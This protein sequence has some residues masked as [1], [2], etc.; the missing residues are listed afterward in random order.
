MKL[1]NL[2]V[3]AACFSGISANA[4]I[5]PGF[6]PGNLI[7]LRVG[8]GT[9]APASSGDPVFLDEFTPLGV[10]TNTVAVPTNGPA[11]LIIGS[12][13]S[14]GAISL[15]ANSNYVVMVGYNTNFPYTSS[16]ASS[17]SAAVPRGIATIDFNG[18][19]NFITNTKTAFSGNNIRS[20]VSDGSNNFWAAGAVS[21]TV[22]MGAAAPFA[23]VQTSDANSEVV[24]IFNGNLCF[25]SQ[26]TTPIG[27]Y[28]FTGAPVT[29]N[30]SAA[31]LFSTGAGSS[32]YG[33]AIS[34]DNTVAY[35]AADRA[36]TSG[37][38]ILKYTN[39]GAWGLAYT[40][41]TGAGSTAGARG[42]T[43][44]FGQPNVIY[45][46]TA[47]ATANRLITITDTDASAA[48]TVL[49][50]AGANEVFRG[51]QFTPQGSAPSV[52]TPLQS[53]TANQGQSATFTV[54]A[55][56]S[57][58]LYYL[59][60]SNSVPLTGWE[61]ND[62]IT[63]DTTTNEATGSFP[64][65][66]LISNSWGTSSS[67]TTLTINPSNVPPA[68]PI[69]LEPP[70]SEEVNASSNASFAVVAT[71]P[72]LTYQ[73][74]WNNT[75]LTN[76]DF[77]SGATTPDLTLSNVFGAS[78]GSY[79]VII[80]N[81]GG[82]KISAPATLAV[83]DPWISSQPAGRTFLAG[84]T[85]ELPAIAI[86]TAVNYQ[87]TF[88]GANIPGAT[89][90]IFAPSNAVA[91]QT[92]NYAVIASG[93]YGMVTSATAMVI[94]APPQTALFP[95]NLVV[96]RLG[97]GS[98]ALINSGN[99]LFLDQYVSNGS[100][101]ST[102]A[103]PDSGPSALL[104]SGVASSEGFMT[105]SG[106]S[107]LLAVA[108]YN[109][110]RGALSGSLSSSASTNVPRAIGTIDGT[111]QYALAASTTNQ[112]S[113]GNLRAGATDGNGNFWGAGSA[114][115]TWYF[116]NTA[117]AGQVQSSVNNTRVINVANGSLLFS[118][119]SGTSG[120]YS[121]G[122]LPLAAATANLIFAT[123]KSSSPEDF[124]INSA[125][126]L[127]YVADDSPAGGIQRWQFIDGVWTN[128]YTL[129][130]SARS[131]AVDFSGANPVIF[132]VTAET[133]T[134]RLIAITDAGAGSAAVTLAPCPAG[135]LFRAVKFGPELN[136]FPAPALSAAPLAGGQ[137]SVSL[138]GVPGYTYVLESS[139]DLLNWQP[140]QTNIA[141]FT[142][143]FTNAP[144]SAQKYFRA[145]YFP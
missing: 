70:S 141:P 52:N 6:E 66:V 134:N 60:E 16:L 133:A 93:P 75:N 132:A 39:N 89:S 137:F 25:S 59:W 1:T 136:P 84:T 26:K 116:G 144:G 135:E 4:Q 119:Q 108:G 129:G 46:T 115:G 36:T 48:V 83:A 23:F 3:L 28:A 101:V 44:Q 50:A 2:L 82:Y 77:I 69:I 62:T 34:P 106:D 12:A 40:F 100:Y 86:G 43:V 95:S 111:G 124:A 47:D 97:D 15:S 90:G 19:Y 65:E 104:I 32:L 74:Q 91:A 55:S 9:A 76:G 35:V 128:V 7:V 140:L 138:A 41:G 121:L 67:S 11:A 114:G 113:G 27:V 120:L 125:S 54:G 123:G 80:S 57:G 58:T 110:N 143:T 64:V 56:G 126:N 51:V 142:L 88:D 94:V 81:G 79:T 21:G 87:W 20:G 139:A 10:L 117:P 45:A 98:Q 42:V 24:N 8:N 96:L 31:L 61:T 127:V 103:L 109:T 72:S 22:Y 30:T 145:A 105:L 78:D 131:L 102:M 33:F 14:E 130:S 85:I 17:T 63:L 71:G 68:A 73:W 29:T 107:R 18:N 5:T 53:Q 38:G 37:G 92:G 13:T 49:A 112:Y 118:T 122:G 99:T